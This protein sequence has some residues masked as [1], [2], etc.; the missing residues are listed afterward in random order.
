M[1]ELYK[2][3]GDAN[4]LTAA[5]IFDEETLFAPI[6]QGNDI[7]EG[8]HANTQIPKFIG[9][10]NRFRAIGTSEAYYFDTAEQFWS[11]VQN[12]HTY[13]T[14]G[15]SRLEHFRAPGQLDAERD[16]TNNETCNTYNM[17]KLTRELFKITTDVKYAD[18]YERAFINEILSAIHP[19][20]GMTSYFKPMGTG[21]FKVFGRETDTFWCCNGSGMENFTKLN[22]GIYFHD[23]S[24][25]Y[26]NMFVPPARPAPAPDASCRTSTPPGAPPA[27]DRSRTRARGPRSTCSSGTGT[28]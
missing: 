3:T 26:I 28:R 16:A 14:G 22:D 19:E 21:Y 4:H 1:Y 18:F 27:R 17:M 8:N 20:T 13:V 2:L 9:S 12:N 7:L 23:E 11:I 6:S 25:L 10:L 15:N 24:D 5:H